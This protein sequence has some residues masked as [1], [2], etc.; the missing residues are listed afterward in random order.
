MTERDAR[1]AVLEAQIRCGFGDT[2]GHKIPA[3]WRTR[4]PDPDFLGM[5]VDALYEVPRIDPHVE[6]V[7]DTAIARKDIGRPQRRGPQP[8]YVRVQFD[9]RRMA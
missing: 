7:L 1:F 8:R 5:A 6:A 9:A 2:P 3:D 4:R